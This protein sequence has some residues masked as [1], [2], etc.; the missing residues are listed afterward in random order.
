VNQIRGKD[1]G[2][3]LAVLRHSPKAVARDVEKLLRAAVANAQQG[4]ERLDVDRLYVS[5]AFVDPG[6]TEKRIRHRA[7]GRVFRI[8]K[9]RCHVTLQLDARDG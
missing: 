7:M 6:P 9:R 2:P 8:L 1:V 5:K 4:E 3:A